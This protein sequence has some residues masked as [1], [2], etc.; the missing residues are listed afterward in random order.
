MIKNKN[1]LR[2][3]A[4]PIIFITGFL[5]NWSWFEILIFYS[6]SIIVTILREIDNKILHM[7]H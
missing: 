1:T 6:V 3:I 4:I 7:F 2:I 5:L